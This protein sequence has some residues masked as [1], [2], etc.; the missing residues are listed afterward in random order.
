VTLGPA[1]SLACCG[2][3]LVLVTACAGSR[4][5]TAH[6]LPAGDARPAA[7]LA[8]FVREADAHRALRGVAHLALDAPNASGRAKQILLVERPA[9]LRVEVLGLLDQTLAL[10]V[11]DGAR[12]RL[13]RSEDR[14]V[15]QGPVHDG[16]LAEVAGI[17]LTPELAVRVLLAAPIDAGAQAIGGA[18]L[19][20]GGLRVLLAGDGLERDQLDFDADAHLRRWTRLGVDGEPLLEASWTDW[21]TA[22]AADFPHEVEI[23]DRANGAR[24]RLTWSRLELDPA[25]AP[26][27]FAVP[28]AA[29]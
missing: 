15:E 22:G 27:L 19:S 5:P 8:A 9:R 2:L 4:G 28:D 3:L 29:P 10:L 18:S 1:R 7:A 6:P 11:T 13:V 24:A 20:D 21:R 17:A 16:L 14:S 12:Y 26:A 23:A 25:L